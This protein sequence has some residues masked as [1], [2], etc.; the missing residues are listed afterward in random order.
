MI[1]HSYTDM[2]SIISVSVKRQQLHLNVDTVKPSICVCTAVLVVAP[3]GESQLYC[4]NSYNVQIFVQIQHKRTLK[5]YFVLTTL[6]HER[7]KN[8]KAAKHCDD[9]GH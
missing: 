5:L 2:T 9:L 6:G 7:K 1:N 3:T 4:Q 8:F